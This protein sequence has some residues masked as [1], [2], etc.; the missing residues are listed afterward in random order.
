MDVAT[1]EGIAI[2]TYEKFDLDP[3]EPASTFLLAK[4]LLGPTCIVRPDRMASPAALFWQH[5]ERRI[6]LRRTVPL[7]YAQFYVG[8]EL[9]HLLLESEKYFEDD[10]EAACDYLAGALM[11]PR[12][13]MR[14]LRRTFG[15]DYEE[16][17]DAVGATQSWAALRMGEV[18]GQP[19]ALVAPQRVRIRGDEWAWPASD[20]QVRR[21]A[22]MPTSPGLQR[23]RLTDDSRRIVVTVEERE[24]A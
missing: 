10:L 9:G 3:S 1:L 2:A 17:A 7:E 5:G 15:F 22:Q 13:S 14:L 16:I 24:T 6:A 8:H 12:P 4:K 11:A 21:L 18:T 20:Q 23:A 19:M